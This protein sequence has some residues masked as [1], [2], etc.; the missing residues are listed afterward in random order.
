[1]SWSRTAR[2]L[3]VPYDRLILERSK[4]GVTTSA[5]AGLQ[6]LPTRQGV[7]LD[8]PHP[9]RELMTAAARPS[10]DSCSPAMPAACP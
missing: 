8:R 3:V 9:A 6:P 7:A 10:H 1:L 2:T 4:A 5:A